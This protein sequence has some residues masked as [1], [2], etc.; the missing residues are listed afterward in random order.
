MTGRDE[1]F[2]LIRALTRLSANSDFHQ[3]VSYLDDLQTEH[4][5]ALRAMEGLHLHRNQGRS[6][7]LAEMREFIKQA[8]LLAQQYQQ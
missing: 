5:V 3:F 1:E 7:L 8:P 2:D 4:D 6:Q